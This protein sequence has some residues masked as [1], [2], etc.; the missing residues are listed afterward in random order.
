MIKLNKKLL[1]S[2]IHNKVESGI[3]TPDPIMVY[4]K[5]SI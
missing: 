3:L 1:H 5:D 4:L 2:L